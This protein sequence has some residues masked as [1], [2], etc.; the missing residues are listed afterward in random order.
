MKTIGLITFYDIPCELIL[1]TYHNA[2]PALI[3]RDVETGQIFAKVSINITDIVPD[4]NRWP[5]DYICIKTW[6]ENAGIFEALVKENLVEDTGHSI[7]CGPFGAVAR[8]V[9]IKEKKDENI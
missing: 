3:L 4:H 7:P 1:T 5:K 9:T 6:S 2:L 8:V